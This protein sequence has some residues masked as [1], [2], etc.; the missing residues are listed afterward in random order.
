MTLR[1]TAIQSKQMRDSAANVLRM[2][3][4]REKSMNEHVTQRFLSEAP[5]NLPANKRDPEF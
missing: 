1:H 3:D 4:T 5:V 2:G